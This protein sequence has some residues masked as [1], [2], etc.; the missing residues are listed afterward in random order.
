MECVKEHTS[1]GN[2]IISKV[3][4]K[5]GMIPRAR[6]NTIILDVRMEY[7]RRRFSRKLSMNG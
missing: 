6:H 2:S 7:K 3:V 5:S 4:S 1:D